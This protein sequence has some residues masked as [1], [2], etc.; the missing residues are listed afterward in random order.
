[1]IEVK[2]VSGVKDAVEVTCSVD[3]DL[4]ALAV[5]TI[6][7]INGVFNAIAADSGPA[8]LALFQAVIMD[9]VADDS[10]SVWERQKNVEE[11]PSC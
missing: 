10:S 7:V 9:A 1:V 8:E 11:V 6:A 3:G 4:E 2:A 5:E